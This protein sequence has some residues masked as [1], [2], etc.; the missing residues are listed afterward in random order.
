MQEGNVHHS[1]VRE[2]KVGKGKQTKMLFKR[3]LK[4]I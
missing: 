3:Y 2:S 1:K 4:G